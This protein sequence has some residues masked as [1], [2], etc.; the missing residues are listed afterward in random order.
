MADVLTPAMLARRWGVSTTLIYDMLSAG[1]LPAFRLGKLWR[2]P[3]AAVE[4]V[5]SGSGPAAHSA[6]PDAAEALHGPKSGSCREALSPAAI[7][8]MAKRLGDF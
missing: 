5:E 3:A 1:S 7:T 4:A 8:R 6:T 2:I